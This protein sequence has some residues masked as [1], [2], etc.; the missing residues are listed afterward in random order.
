MSCY[1]F[2]QEE[3]IFILLIHNQVGHLSMHIKINS[4]RR[5][6]LFIIMNCFI[7]CITNIQNSTPRYKTRAKLLNHGL[8]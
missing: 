4:K 7:I 8:N 6:Y 1:C 3:P 2:H 5:K